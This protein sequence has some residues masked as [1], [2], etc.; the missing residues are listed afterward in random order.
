MIN[1]AVGG[2]ISEGDLA[3]S[4]EADLIGSFLLM[5][6]AI[7]VAAAAAFVFMLFKEKK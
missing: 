5:L 7:G 4:S 3:V 2:F 6:I 1:K